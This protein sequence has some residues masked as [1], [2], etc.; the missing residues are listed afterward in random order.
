[1]DGVLLIAWLNKKPETLR[2]RFQVNTGMNELILLLFYQE[3]NL[4]IRKKKIYGNVS[5]YLL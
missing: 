1:M 5:A 2:E 3:N 4:G